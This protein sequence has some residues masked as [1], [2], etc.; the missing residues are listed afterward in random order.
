M[1]NPCK[2]ETLSRREFVSRSVVAGAGLLAVQGGWLTSCTATIPGHP[3]I[4]LT[5]KKIGALRSLREVQTA[6]QSGHSGKLWQRILEKVEIDRTAEPLTPASVFP[7]RDANAAKHANPDYTVCHEAGQRILRAALANLL[8]GEAKP[9]NIAL[10][11]MEAL[12]DPQRWPRWLDDAH[13]RFGHPA[14][15]RTGMLS[16]DVALAYDWLY[17][18]LS[19]SER[20]FVLEG[21]DRCGIQPYL[22][23]LQQDPWWMHDLNNWLTVIVGGL[24]VAGMALGNDHPDAQKLIDVAL[25]KMA[26]YM[27]TYGPEGEFNESVAYAGATR[28][29]ATFYLAHLYWSAGGENKLSEPP[30]P[31]TCEWVMYNTLPPGRVAAYGDA[32][33]N[34]PVEVKYFP[35]V[36][37]ATNNPFLQWFYLAYAQENADP[38]EF[39]W[40]DVTLQPRS[41][42]GEWPLG[43][44]FAAHGATLTSRTSWDALSTACVV[45]G[46][47]GREENHENNDIGQLC[48]DGFGERL[49]V[50]LG[51]PSGYP[52]D[53][54]EEEARWKYYNAGVI[55]H[56]VL[57]FG[58]REMLVTSQQRSEKSE[59]DFAAYS[60]KILMAE[61]DD[62]VG[63]MWRIDAGNAY[64]GVVSVQ[65]TVVHLFPGVIA[66]LD[67][68]T[69]DKSESISLR[70]HTATRSEPDARGAFRVLGSKA[71][72]AGQ[73][74]ALDAAELRFRRG[75]HA[76]KAPYDKDRLGEPLEQRHENYVEALQT[77]KSCR[78]LTLF[79]VEKSDAAPAEWQ[80]QADGWAVQTAAGRV[81]MH[82]EGGVLSVRNIDTGQVLRAGLI[83]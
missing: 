13:E 49:I 14:D 20:D 51:A 18:S 70:W 61:F 26:E 42:Q 29:P 30:L 58:G 23:S 34:H 48:I 21:L 66:V 68:A 73:I 60:G 22:I 3:C 36:A 37:S 59:I 27:Q 28:M 1:N 74:I 31:Q 35:A 33:T 8:T 63:N 82:V 77:A 69:L 50:D 80:R 40:Y 32:K 25:Q 11:Q 83:G 45:Y 44:A 57:M 17:P 10:R 6:A 46:K 24:G 12:F 4:Y 52:E 9:K 62:A 39:L 54:F 43:R 78:L 15:L 81:V 64:S 75:Q 67:E 16:L 7:G 47:A 19:Q 71:Q 5:A 56:N 79:A 76:Y 53:F 72:L 55:G 2:K 38:L 65:R 41:P